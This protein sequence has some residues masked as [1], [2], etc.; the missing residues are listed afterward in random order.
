MGA[1]DEYRET[2]TEFIYA[3]SREVAGILGQGDGSYGAAA[4]KAMTTIGMV[5]R[6]MLGKDGTYS[7]Q[8]QAVG[9][10]RSA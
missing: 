6:Q 1:P 7:G 8:R 5:S 10:N 4:V 2:D 9:P 3:T